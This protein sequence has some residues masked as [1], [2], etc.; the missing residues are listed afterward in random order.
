MAKAAIGGGDK[1]SGG[2]DGGDE[3]NEMV[4]G[5]WENRV[6]RWEQRK[7]SL[8]HQFGRMERRILLDWEEAAILIRPGRETKNW[9]WGK[10]DEVLRSFR[11]M[12][13]EMEELKGE[14]KRSG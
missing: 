8:F 9:H 11:G 14:V 10:K 3:D 1:E 7:G 13:Q 6:E 5:D 12:G 2:Q 4:T